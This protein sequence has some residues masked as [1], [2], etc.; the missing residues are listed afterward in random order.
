VLPILTFIPV[1]SPHSGHEATD[2][3]V[4]MGSGSR[5]VEFAVDQLQKRGEK[6]GVLARPLRLPSQNH[7]QSNDHHPVGPI[8]FGTTFRIAIPPF[9]RQHFSVVGPERSGRSD[10]DFQFV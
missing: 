4:I 3:V 9:F 8:L 6:V 5:S 7:L 1:L 2:V 10:P